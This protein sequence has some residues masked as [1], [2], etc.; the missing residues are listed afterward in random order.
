MYAL[1]HL[2]MALR[3]CWGSTPVSPWRAVA[4]ALRRLPPRGVPTLGGFGWW[5]PLRSG[6]AGGYCRSSRRC[7][8]GS[9][10]QEGRSKV[11][12]AEGYVTYS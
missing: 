11:L 5:P 4:K 7:S 6:M 1:S 10:E 3:R 12:W 2:P 9:P 8:Y